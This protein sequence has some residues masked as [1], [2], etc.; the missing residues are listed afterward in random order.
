VSARPDFSILF[1]QLGLPDALLDLESLRVV[2]YTNGTP[3]EPISYQE[4][5]SVLLMDGETL[6]IRS[7]NDP[8][9][10][11]EPYWTLDEDQSTL[12][13]DSERFTQG[14]HSIRGEIFRHPLLSP[15]PGITYKVRD[16][17]LSD[18]SSYETLMYDVW[19]EVNESAIDQTTDLYLLE[20]EGAENCAISQFNSPSLAMDQWNRTTTSLVPLGECSDADLSNLEGLRFLLSPRQ[21]GGFDLDDRLTLW[22]DNLRLV[23]QDG[24]GEI[25]WIAEDGIDGY[26]LYFDTINHTGHPEPERTTFSGETFSTVVIGEPEA[27][28]YFN[29][30]SGVTSTDLSVWS[31][32]TVEKIF[33]P[34]SEP[35]TEKPLLIQAAR[36]EFEAFQLVFQSP[37]DR[38]LPVTISDLVG[39]NGSISSGQ[40]QIFRVDYVPLSEIS[41][42]YG[43]PVDWP[44]PLYP[45]S[46]GGP[47]HLTTGENQPLWVRVEV[48]ANASG[49]LYTGNL[50]IGSTQIPFSLEVWDFTLPDHGYLD[51]S[52]EFDWETVLSAYSASAPGTPAVCK[53]QLETAV[54]DTLA[55][56]HLIPNPE[57]DGVR[58]YRLT[59]YEV[60]TAQTYQAQT[61][62]PVWWEFY[63]GDQPPFAN[64][65]VIDRPGLDARILPGLAWQDRVD[66]LYYAQAVDWDSDPWVTP[67]TNYASNGDGFL[68][69][70]P[71]DGRIGDDPCRADSNRL[72]PSIRLELLREGM[73]DYAYLQLLNSHAPEIGVENESDLQLQSLISS[74]TAF[75][76]IPT[77]IDALRRA[78]ADLIHNT[79]SRYFLPFVTR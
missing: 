53:D 4:T 79:D 9:Y 32:P 22:L 38:E 76:R 52:V 49:G 39:E 69:Y 27:G 17:A 66:G 61:G 56:Y 29:R 43:R 47:V 62:L 7:E 24:E 57:L 34:Q 33:K 64:P 18:W 21:P 54:L 10:N 25:R 40:V 67:F 8:G 35:V 71:N 16:T 55:D 68:F 60:Q 37:M 12:S 11:S 19:P 3:G 36:R 59:D 1:A 20:F 51:V 5:L 74:R 70:P 30:I 72:I 23:D 28:G 2:P 42:F 26:Y 77:R 44:D 45:L 13:L 48:P 15:E 31:A 14:I 50:T 73:E 65:A 78:I 46:P 75:N 41:D 6:N 58:I 63:Y